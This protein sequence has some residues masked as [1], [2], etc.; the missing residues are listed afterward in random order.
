M[1]STQRELSSSRRAPSLGNRPQN[2]ELT[3]P[4]LWKTRFRLKRTH[5]QQMVRWF[6][7]ASMVLALMSKFPMHRQEMDSQQLIKSNLHSNRQLPRP[8]RAKASQPFVPGV[9]LQWTALSQR[10]YFSNLSWAAYHT[11]HP[12]V[13]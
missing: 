4:S 10:R 1:I 13:E 11:S 2:A 3:S 5:L 7:R 12:R 8:V 9:S 6:L